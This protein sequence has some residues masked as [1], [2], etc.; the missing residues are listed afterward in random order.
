MFPINWLSV[1][2]Y[3]HYTGSGATA[4][5]QVAFCKPRNEKV[6]I[7]RIDLEQYKSSF[8]ELQVS[9]WTQQIRVN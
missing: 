5:V 2:L 1:Y 7:K 8:T 3:V 9:T 4:V 6:A